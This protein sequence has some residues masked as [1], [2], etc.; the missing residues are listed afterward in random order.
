MSDAGDLGS[1]RGRLSD[2]RRRMLRSSVRHSSAS[3]GCRRTGSP[4]RL[5]LPPGAC[6]RRANAA[7]DSDDAASGSRAGRAG[8]STVWPLLAA[9]HG[10]ASSSTVCGPIPRPFYPLASPAPASSF[11]PLLSP[12]PDARRT[13]Q[14]NQRKGAARPWPRACDRLDRGAI[15]RRNADP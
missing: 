4:R 3:Y 7:Y 6:Q 8:R 14:P 15:A 13:R 9:R 1:R 5:R 2:G 10:R 12:P 11:N